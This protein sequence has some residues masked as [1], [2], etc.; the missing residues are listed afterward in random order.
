M[1]KPRWGAFYGTCLDG[2]LRELGVDTLLFAGCNLPNCPRASIVQASERDFHVAL[3]R[4]AVSRVTDS[5]LSE[6]AG[7]GVEFVDS[8]ALE[9]V[10]AP[11]GPTS[12]NP[13]A[14]KSWITSRT[15]PRG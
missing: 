6:L 12:A 11:S 14:L 10:L 3:V 15:R 4:D 1:F 13:L 7:I 5:A 9:Q 2:L 8:I